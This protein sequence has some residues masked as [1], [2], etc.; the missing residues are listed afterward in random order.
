VDTFDRKKRSEVM[1]KIRGRGNA[2]TEL[3]VAN[4][5][6]SLGITGWRRHL[7]II[8]RPDFVFKKSKL[9]LFVDGCFWHGC[10]KCYSAPTSSKDF[11]KDKLAKNMARDLAVNRQLR[12][13]GWRVIRVWECQLNEPARFL[14]RIAKIQVKPRRTRRD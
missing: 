5:F 3:K 4:L 8:G 7:P 12:A 6:R 9:A 14:G 11:W 2:S 10:P 1:S 13:Q